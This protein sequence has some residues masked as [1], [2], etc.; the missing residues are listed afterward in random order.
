MKTLRLIQIMQSEVEV[1]VEDEDYEHFL[2]SFNNIYHL[3]EDED[4]TTY[5]KTIVEIEDENGEIIKTV[6]K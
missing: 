4:F 5:E 6:E 3:T 1:E 2:K